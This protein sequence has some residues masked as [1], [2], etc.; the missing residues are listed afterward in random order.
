MKEKKKDNFFHELKEIK[1][2]QNTEK[3]INSKYESIK[4]SILKGET[5]FF[6]RI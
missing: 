1:F 4:K 5:H 2:I 3:Q 6:K